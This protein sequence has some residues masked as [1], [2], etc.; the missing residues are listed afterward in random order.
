MTTWKAARNGAWLALISVSIGAACS[1][2]SDQTEPDLV[3]DVVDESSRAHAIV[4]EVRE[5]FS[6]FRSDD[7]P[8]SW[9]RT[10]G[11]LVPELDR[12]GSRQVD[13]VLPSTLIDSFLVRDRSSSVSIE[14]R[15]EGTL[16]VA[17]E[18]ADGLLLYPGA[19]DGHDVI[20]RASV[21]GLEDFIVFDS[22]PARRSCA[23]SSTSVKPW[24]AFARLRT[25]SNL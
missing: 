2:S 21:S 13:I 15:L 3:R 11:G 4:D 1:G 24:R 16:N 19:L 17:P 6:Q 14:V 20:Y 9:L 8:V 5:T 23:M 18:A 22:R 7:E 12:D 10:A 25:W